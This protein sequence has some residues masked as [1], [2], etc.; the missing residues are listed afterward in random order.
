MRSTT[1]T[2]PSAILSFAALLMMPHAPRV[3]CAV[4]LAVAFWLAGAGIGVFAY[5]QY[6]RAHAGERQ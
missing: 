5:E 3:A 4:V 1:F 2:I 6:E